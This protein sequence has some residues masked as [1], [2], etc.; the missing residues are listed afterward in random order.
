MP[1]PGSSYSSTWQSC[2]ADE[3]RVALF[4]LDGRLHLVH[5]FTDDPSAL[6]EAAQQLASTPSPIMR[7][8]RE[9][10]EEK[11]L[12][13]ETGATKN[14]AMYRSLAGFLWSE[15]EGKIESRTEMTMQALDE[16]AH[17]VAV[18][19][20]R[21]N[22]IW[23]SGGIPFDP[24]DT[25]PQLQ[26]TAALLAATDIAV[27]PVDVRGVAYLGADAAAPSST[28]FAAR[29]GDYSSTT[30]QGDEL[31]GVRQTMMD[32]ARLTGGQAYYNR[33]DLASEVDDIVSAGAS[34]YILAYRPQKETWDG[35][36]RKITVK[37]LKA[38]LKVQCRPG[39]Y[40]VPDPFR[41]PDI[42]RT[43]A[44]AMQPGVPPSTTLVIQARV[45]PPDAPDKATQVDFLVDM[46]DLTLL[47]SAD[48]LQ[49]PDVMFVAAAWDRTGK[50]Q[51]SVSGTYQQVLDAGALK[52]LMRTGLH[53]QHQFQLSPG[54]YD[55]RVGVVDRLS[56]KIGTIDVPLTVES[57]V[58]RN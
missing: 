2:Q 6:M 15:Y 56:G 36:F 21:K 23:I 49:K 11:A 46:H 58:A 43:F 5:G 10:S 29:G 26:K 27:Y 55:L 35:K 51:G 4:T 54:T 44:L 57:K 39:Y 28:V 22:L 37:P 52:T 12:A 14:P 42:D 53:L 31:L 48:H 19:P 38:G 20:G 25:A 17:N 9:V 45:L 33:N 24:T 30:G 50:A 7:K 32:M 34:Y 40:A 18:F 16:L 13:A 41:S 3:T 1:S 8:A 47:Q